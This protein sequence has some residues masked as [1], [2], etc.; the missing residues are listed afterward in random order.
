MPLASSILPAVVVMAYNRPDSLRR[1]LESLLRASY[2]DEVPLV[3]SI[4]KSKTD[5]VRKL[6]ESFDWPFAKKR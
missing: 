2:P 1:L 4:D 6:A 3:I 5:T